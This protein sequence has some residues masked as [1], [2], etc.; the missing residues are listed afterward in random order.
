M[1]IRIKITKRLYDIDVLDALFV[2]TCA[3][4]GITLG[5]AIL[6]IPS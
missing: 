1:N 2:W 5:L 4:I 6:F 3:L